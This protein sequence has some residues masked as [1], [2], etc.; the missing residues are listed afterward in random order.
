VSTVVAANQIS[1]DGQLV[2]R[3]RNGAEILLEGIS[4]PKSQALGHLR[5]NRGFYTNTYSRTKNHERHIELF[6]GSPIISVFDRS[7]ETGPSYKFSLSAIYSH[8]TYFEEYK[9]TTS[10]MKSVSLKPEYTRLPFVIFHT[11][12]QARGVVLYFPHPAEERRWFSEDYIVNKSA[13]FRI[14]VRLDGRGTHVEATS[15]LDAIAE[16]RA[17]TTQEG[18]MM[19]MPFDSG[20]H[21][22]MEHF[23]LGRIPFHEKE[24]KQ[25][26]DQMNYWSLDTDHGAASDHDIDLV[27]MRRYYPAE[28]ASWIDSTPLAKGHEGGFAWGM[29][30][31]SMKAIRVNPNTKRSL[32]RDHAFRM[33]SFFLEAGKEKGAP[34]LLVDVPSWSQRF[35]TPELIYSVVF[36]QFWE[37]RLPEFV[38]LLDSPFLLEEEKEKLYRDLQRAKSVYDPESKYSWSLPAGPKGLWFDYFDVKLSPQNAWIINTHA[39]AVNNI[40][41]FAEISEMMKQSQDFAYWVELFR[42]GIRGLLYATGEKWMWTKDDANELAYG[43]YWSGPALYHELMVTVWLPE[44]IDHAAKIAPE[45]SHHLIELLIRCAKANML[46]EDAKK[47]ENVRKILSRYSPQDADENA[48]TEAP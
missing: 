32:F 44:M 38:A 29:T 25:I 35:A 1:S 4:Q 11:E 21:R 43:R 9:K 15:M 7:T 23:Q 3:F 26:Q 27:Y 42:Q 18:P 39:T 6:R 2:S 28:F 12:D 16:N 22:A 45:L 20:L 17:R 33:L 48:G 13:G 19:I 41:V 47:A 31:K 30:T 34:P 10:R 24:E 46:F 8:V 14:K 37:F 40:G 5:V 36:C